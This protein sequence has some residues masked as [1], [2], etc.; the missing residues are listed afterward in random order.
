MRRFLTLV[1][2]TAIAIF[3]IGISPAV[4][5][6]VT[7]SDGGTFTITSNVVSNG[8]TCEGEA[9]I[10]STVTEIASDGFNQATLLTKVTFAG[11]SQLST[12]GNF[13]FIQA[14][15]LT[16]ITIPASVTTIGNYAF[17][18][19]SLL[20]SIS[21][22][23]NVTSIGFNA[24]YLSGITNFSVDALNDTYSSENN[25]LF[26][27]N[28]T[29]LIVFLSGTSGPYAIPGSVTEI[30]AEA[31]TNRGVSSVSIPTSVRTIGEFAFADAPSLSN[32]SIAE[33]ITSI[34]RNAFSF[35]LALDSLT[36]PAS[37]S[38]IDA[39]AFDGGLNS[40]KLYFLGDAPTTTQDGDFLIA[41]QSSAFARVGA[42][43]FGGYGDLWKGL[44]LVKGR[45]VTFSGNGN[46]SGSTP[47]TMMRGVGDEI[48]I[49]NN[50]GSLA[51]AGYTFA[52]W[53]QL[54]SGQGTDYIATQLLTIPDQDLTLNAKWTANLNTV[55]YNSASGTAINPGSFT[56]GGTIQTAPVS[57]RTG[58]TF[59][60]WSATDG[61]SIVTFPYSPS[62][63]SSI[64]LYA[65]WTRNLVKAV[66]STK[67]TITG[68]ATATTKGTNKLTAKKGTWTGYP[69]PVI[70]YQWYSCTSQ[71]KS[72]TSTIPKSCKKISKATKSTLAVTNAFKGK[73]IAVAVTGKGTGTTATT[74]LSKSTAKV[75]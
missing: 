54:T 55:T 62:A 5:A 68:K 8:T 15:S 13:A 69:T 11:E 51:K 49:P 26:D 43:G 21:I 41:P 75:K 12:I 34:G 63:T 16:S 17:A 37:V 58:Y 24:F 29:T 9:I 64:T 56:T 45:V 48:T 57:T 33:G 31:F 53:N 72:A 18:G 22:P 1:I 46:S 35:T 27:I 42:I 20:T 52:G 70:S 59:V 25:V 67:P 50:S 73:F 4:A 47:A 3:G 6:T 28:K 71:V 23:A 14:S 40:K 7:C 66:V 61:G 60:G 38:A 36:I 19:T 65:I 44:T 32:I 39:Q 2:S 10:P 74:W 30:S